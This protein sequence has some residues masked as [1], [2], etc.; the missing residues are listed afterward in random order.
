MVLVQ[1]SVVKL[2][3]GPQKTGWHG[4]VPAPEGEALQILVQDDGVGMTAAEVERLNETGQTAKERTAEHESIGYNNV[5][6]I[7]RLHYGEPYGLYTESEKGV[8]TSV[9]LTLPL[10]PG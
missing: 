5:E 7:I 6:A 10:C 2:A 9:Y 1:A 8:G 4:D 3:D